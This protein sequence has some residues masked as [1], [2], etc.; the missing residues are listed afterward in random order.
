MRDNS[1]NL[2][3]YQGNKSYYSNESLNELVR[4]RES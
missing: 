4:G 1:W 2:Q 3:T